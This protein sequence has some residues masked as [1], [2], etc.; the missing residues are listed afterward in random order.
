[1]LAC[2]RVKGLSSSNL[3]YTDSLI[4]TD[5]SLDNTQSF[6]TDGEVSILVDYILGTNNGFSI[7][8]DPTKITFISQEFDVIVFE[9]IW[10]TDSSVNG[11]LEIT[12]YRNIGSLPTINLTISSTY[13]SNPTLR[14]Y[15]GSTYY[16]ISLG[17][18]INSSNSPIVINSSQRY[19]MKNLVYF[20]PT[21]FPGINL[22]EFFGVEFI[23]DNVREAIPISVY[24]K[25]FNSE[26]QKLRFRGNI[27]LQEVY[28]QID[29]SK[30]YYNSPYRCKYNI[31]DE[32]SIEF[33]R[34]IVDDEIDQIISSDKTYRVEMIG[35]NYDDGSQKIYKLGNVIFNNLNMNIPDGDLV[36]DKITGTGVWL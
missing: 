16:D 6:N 23:N 10:I 36:T 27:T 26:F 22:N 20:L 1:M 30:K 15:N 8:T 7:I 34:N 28:N 32:A 33:N 14:V 24:Y 35:L 18:L 25:K 17:S 5:R 21:K 31:L 4:D 9:E 3:L 29:M 13:S 2:R 11:Y 12:N 19:A